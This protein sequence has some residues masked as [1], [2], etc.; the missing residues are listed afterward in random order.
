MA[1]WVQEPMMFGVQTQNEHLDGVPYWEAPVPRRLHLC[2]AQ[3]RGWCGYFT[4]VERCACGGTRRNGTGRWI[5]RNSERKGRKPV[6]ETPY[7]ERKQ[8]EADRWANLFNG[9]A[10]NEMGGRS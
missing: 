5:E 4:L 7:I 1:K 6:P 8:A 2:T 3:T 10:M 9:D